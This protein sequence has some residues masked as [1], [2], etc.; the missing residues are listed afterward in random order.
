MI[1][2]KEDN[3]LNCNRLFNL[4]C[5]TSISKI[6]KTITLNV[7]VSLMHILLLVSLYYAVVVK[8]KS[9]K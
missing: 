6:R 4:F 5:I 3:H 2:V 1:W 8:Q 9:Q 7:T